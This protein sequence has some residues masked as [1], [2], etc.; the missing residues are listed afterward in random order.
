[1]EYNN[2]IRDLVGVDFNP[3]DDFPADDIGYGFDNI[4]DVLSL[5]PLLLEKYLAAAEKILGAAIV[6]SGSTN[7][8]TKRLQAAWLDSTA[9]GDPYT[10]T[11]RMLSREG[12][13]YTTFQCL[14]P[15]EYILRARAFG[16]Q[17]GPDP[18][19]MEFR[20]DNK[21]IKVFDV[22]A[23]ERKPAIYESQIQLAAGNRRLGAAYINNYVNKNDPDPN[24]RDR[25]L[26]V[27]YLEIVGPLG[28]QPLPESHK[29]IFFRTPTASNKAAVAREIIDRFARRAYRRPLSAAETKRLM[30][31][32]DSTADAGDDFESSVKLALQ[33]VLVSPHFLFR[34]ESQPQPDNIKAVYPVDEFALASRLS[35]FLW[36][37]M[38][39]DELFKLAEQGKLRKNL[40]VQTRR[41]LK[42]PKARALTENF[43]GQ[44]LQIRNLATV[45]PDSKEFPGFD[46]ALR[47]SMAQETELFFT[48]IVQRDRSVLEFLTADY[49][50]VNERLAQHYGIKNVRG[51]EFQRVSQKGTRRG[52]LLT[53]ASFLTVT[54][55]ATRTSPVKRGKWVL[56]NIL[57]TPPP[58]PPPD[59]PPFPEGHEAAV[60][61][62]LRQRMERHRTDPVCSSCHSRMDPIGFGFE[63]FDAIGAWRE[64]DGKFPI[65]PSGQLAGGEVF[66]G[67]E[68]LKKILT[69]TQRDQ[70]VRCLAGKML[71]YGLGR[72][73][74][75]YD[76]C[77]VDEIAKGMKAGGYRFSSL[78]MGVVNSVP[79]QMRRG[80][81]LKQTA[82]N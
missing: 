3:A 82:A 8:T 64:Q 37:S 41:M 19:R 17:A 25:N 40:E 35:Y 15:G 71:T 13:V 72:G 75:H 33:A 68:D 60:S 34:G 9:P 44:W 81:A 48:D 11:M 42:D 16:Q 79:F 57:G 21:M 10:G 52:G 43:A 50:F 7:G 62:T 23:V 51:D 18:A 31:F 77:A 67:P 58:P 24:N 59:V 45:T 1:V 12:E 20:V 70:F 56:E 69:T 73:L 29:R 39:D 61:G 74:E 26:I 5:S 27:D 47:Q 76:Q 49:T 38:P 65:D 30:R 6:T 78:I 80:E 55:N 63:N 22:T 53:Q 66:R 2:T 4:G 36:S 14:R 46:D 28:P 32:Y 54:S